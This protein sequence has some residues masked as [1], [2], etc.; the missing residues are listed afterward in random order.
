MMMNKNLADLVQMD[1]IT[2]QMITHNL[3]KR[4]YNDQ[5]Y[6]RLERFRRVA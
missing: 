2:E 5:I 4:F 6:V 3:R 1:E